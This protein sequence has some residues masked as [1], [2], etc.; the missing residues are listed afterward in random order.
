MTIEQLTKHEDISK[1]LNISRNRYEYIL[2]Y[3]T[4]MLK[5]YQGD[6]ADIVK[7]IPLNLKGKERYFAMHIMGY[8]SS[9]A[10]SRMNDKDKA[11]FIKN[12]MDA[13]RISQEKAESITHQMANDTLEEMKKDHIPTVIETIKK[14][15]DSDFSEIEKDY[16][17]FTY[18]LIYT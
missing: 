18:G 7:E 5:D 10:F 2:L 12:I 11:G 15:I 16:L 4:Q 6:I 14:V 3:V 13:L 8:Y 1:A 17:L 9:S